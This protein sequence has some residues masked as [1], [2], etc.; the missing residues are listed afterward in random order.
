[1]STNL[2]KASTQQFKLPDF[3]SAFGHATTN[4]VG[5]DWESAKEYLTTDTNGDGMPSWWHRGG[6]IDLDFEAS[7]DSN[8]EDNWRNDYPDEIDD[9][10]LQ[11]GD[12]YDELDNDDIYGFDAMELKDHEDGLENSDDEVSD[13]LVYSI[14][15]SA[16][17][18]AV[19]NKHGEAYARYKTKMQRLLGEIDSEDEGELAD[20]SS[21]DSL[22]NEPF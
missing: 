12:D 11:D 9:L 15:G 20:D 16:E 4:I 21:C 2:S 5:C 6:D 7:D 19:S 3:K 10:N 13:K 18:G 17:F 14:D 1:M 22:S 8:A